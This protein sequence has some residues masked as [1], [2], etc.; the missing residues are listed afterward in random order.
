MKIPTRSL[1]PVHP[2]SPSAVRW[3]PAVPLAEL[4]AAAVEKAG[5]LQ[6]ALRPVLE[7]L[8]DLTGTEA[9]FEQAGVEHYRR[10]VGHVISTRH[11]RRLLH[12]TCARDN[13]AEDWSRLEIYLD[14]RPARR[15]AA[16]AKVALVHHELTQVIAAFKNPAQPT[17]QESEYL[18]LRALESFEQRAN[19]GRAEKRA[20]RELLSFLHDRAPFLAGTREGLRKQFERKLHRWL[21][22]N[23]DSKA[24]ADGR[25]ERSGNFRAP[26]LS[27][28]DRDKLVGHA[29]LNTGGRVAQAY[30]ELKREGELSEELTSHYLDNPSSKS[31]VPRHIR[32][33][34]KWDVAMLEDIHHGP[35]QAKLNGPHLER[36][37]SNVFAGDWS[38]ADDVTLPVYYYEPDGKGWFTLWRGQCLLM[39]DLR[40]TRIL[41]YAL[42]SSRNYNS[43]AIRTLITRTCDDHGLPRCGFY[44]ERGVWQSSKILAGDKSAPLLLPE[45]EKGLRDLGLK[46]VHSNL[47]RSKPVERTIGALQN[48]MERIPGYAGRDERHD[49][50]ERVQKL[51]IGRAHV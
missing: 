51:K 19:E 3:Q 21:E 41:G 33:G 36:D 9:E 14:E 4:S 25:R 13:G 34:V 5:R 27:Q 49:R 32:D 12:R 40:T 43:L 7:R 46:F 44:F 20:R 31:Y 29:V 15:P 28:A 8:N 11:W 26:E 18:W 48:L 1:P 45:T 10:E 39:I 42:L 50:F 17:P 35:R 38:Q 6:R 30:R 2:A 23:G 22:T 37:W 24:V 47:P 16:S